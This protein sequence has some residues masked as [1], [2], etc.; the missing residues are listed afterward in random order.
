ML[1]A[2]QGQTRGPML[3]ARSSPKTVYRA[4]VDGMNMTDN[5][6]WLTI[7]IAEDD[8]NLGEALAGLLRDQGHQVDLAGNGLEALEF[9]QNRTYALVIADLVMP[10]ADGLEVLRAAKRKDKATLVVIMTGHASLDSAIQATREGAY[11]YLRK[12]FKL[13][14][15]NIAVANAARLLALHQEN[16]KLLQKLDDLTMQLEKLQDSDQKGGSA[17]PPQAQSKKAHLPSPFD[18]WPGGRMEYQ[19]DLSRLRHLYQESLITEGEYQ[20]LKQRLCI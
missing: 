14:E 2:W 10:G 9:L 5:P 1:M 12:P 18:F 19:S 7:L 17:P 11:D 20:T 3:I 15:I 6:T 13:E 4:P 16:R 8:L